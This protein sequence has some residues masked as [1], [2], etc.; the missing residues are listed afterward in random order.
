VVGDVRDTADHGQF[1]D[2]R[3][4]RVVTPPLGVR[5]ILDRAEREQPARQAPG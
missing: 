1:R 4:P 5:V 3:V 2:G